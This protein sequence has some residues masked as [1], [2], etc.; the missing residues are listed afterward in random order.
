L[1][2]QGIGKGLLWRNGIICV[3]LRN[4]RANKVFAF[5]S[6]F[7]ATFAPFCGNSNPVRPSFPS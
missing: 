2:A 7:F 4:L 5:L 6:L 1:E 3:H